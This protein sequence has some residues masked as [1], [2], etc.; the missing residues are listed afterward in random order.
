[1]YP[2]TITVSLEAITLMLVY[3]VFMSVSEF[4]VHRTDLLGF[5]SDR[6][7]HNKIII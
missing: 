5:T 4:S 2:P 3:T 6:V 7:R 1:M